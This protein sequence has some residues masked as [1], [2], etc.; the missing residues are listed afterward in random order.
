MFWDKDEESGTLEAIGE[1]ESTIE[2]HFR[3][4]DIF[5]EVVCDPHDPGPLSCNP[6]D[7]ECIQFSLKKVLFSWQLKF[8]WKVQGVKQI[9][10]SVKS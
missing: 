8:T 9:N 5:Y 3:P 1:G 4:S 7:K 6:V 10:W 2:L